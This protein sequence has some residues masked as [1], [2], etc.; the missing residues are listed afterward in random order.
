M[1]R[2]VELKKKLSFPNRR[3]TASLYRPILMQHTEHT[4]DEVSLH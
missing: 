1:F 3:H 2:R 4:I